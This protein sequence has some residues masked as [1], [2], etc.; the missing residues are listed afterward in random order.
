MSLRSEIESL[1][2]R[3]QPPPVGQA[4]G[5]ITGHKREE[6]TEALAELEKSYA[7]APNPASSS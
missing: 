6:V 4:F 5:R 7:S 1:S 2:L 3:L